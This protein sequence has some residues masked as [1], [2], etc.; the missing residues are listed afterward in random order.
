MSLDE[1]CRIAE[2]GSPSE[3]VSIAALCRMA[4]GPFFVRRG[5]A[6]DTD[7][8]V[9]LSPVGGF[10]SPRTLLQGYIM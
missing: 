2:W 10:L 4:A 3:E 8:I 6:P 7:R 5:G 9:I 1:R